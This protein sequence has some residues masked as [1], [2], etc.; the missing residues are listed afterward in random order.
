MQCFG[1]FLRRVR[2]VSGE[3]T[4][5]FVS[6]ITV[7]TEKSQK[8]VDFFFRSRGGAAFRQRRRRLRTNMEVKVSVRN[9]GSFSFVFLDPDGH[10][11]AVDAKNGSVF[12]Y[13]RWHRQNA[14]NWLDATF[15]GDRFFQVRLSTKGEF[16]HILLLNLRRVAVT[17]GTMARSRRNMHARQHLKMVKFLPVWVSKKV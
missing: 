16:K 17:S 4:R 15:L 10:T 2:S 3:V 6:P 11:V 5:L 8:L 7:S 1:D 14:K 9:L 13:A 12:G